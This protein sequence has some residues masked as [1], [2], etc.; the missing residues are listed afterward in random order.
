[1]ED[2]ASLSPDHVLPPNWTGDIDPKPVSVETLETNMED[3]ASLSPDH[4]PPP[5][6]TGDI[7]TKPVSVEETSNPAKNVCDVDTDHSGQ[8]DRLTSDS[9]A[10][11]IIDCDRTPNG[12]SEVPKPQHV[13]ISEKQSSTPTESILGQNQTE[14]VPSA[15]GQ[16]LQPIA[17]SN[18]TVGELERQT[19][20]STVTINAPN[21]EEVY[22][23]DRRSGTE[24]IM[25]YRD[26]SSSSSSDDSSLGE[27]PAASGSRYIKAMF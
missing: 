12:A 15:E 9:E 25:S 17:D 27:G 19:E 3:T 20:Q 1:M 26:V 21:V 16:P 24:L 22:Q 6:G 14:E 13:V 2:T 10:P 8:H 7:A 4:V 23:I 18:P 5:S 11:L